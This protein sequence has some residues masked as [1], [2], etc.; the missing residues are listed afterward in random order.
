MIFASTDRAR[1][2]ALPPGADFPQLFAQGL[3]RRLAG[4][5]PESRA[6]I[7]VLV[8]SGRMRRRIRECLVAQGPGLLPRIRLVTEPLLFDGAPQHAPPVAPLRR[9]LELAQLVGTLQAAN[10]NLAPRAAV[11][12]LADSLAR[13]FAEMQAEG[14]GFRALDKL[15]LSNHADHWA[16]AQRFLH[17]AETVIAPDAPDAEGR[18]RAQVE[19]LTAKW[20]DAPPAESMIVAGSTG[21]RGTTALLMKAIARLPQGAVVLP[22]FDFDMP[23]Q[24]WSQLDDTAAAEDHPQYRFHALL[25]SLGLAASD[26]APWDDSPPLPRGPLVSLALRPAPQTD[27]WLREG[28]ALGDLVAATEGLGLI[29]A[30]SPRAEATAIAHCLFDAATRGARA[31]L[32]T[33]DRDLTRR[34]AAALQVWGIS[35]DDSAGR[36][37]GLSAPGRFLRQVAELFLR[38]LDVPKLLALLKHPLAH[39]GSERGAHLLHTR[40]LEL[41]LR[42]RSMPFP[43]AQVLSAFA[44]DDGPRKDWAR[45]LSTTLPAAPDPSPRPLGQLVADHLTLAESLAAGQAGTCAGGLWDE[46]AGLEARAAMDAL[47]T[48]ADAGGDLTP[49]DYDT[50]LANIFAGREVREPVTAHPD[51]MIWGTLEARVQGADLVIAAGLNEGVW[52]KAPDPD[53]W[54]NRAMRAQVGLLLPDRQIGLSAHDFQQAV[55]APRVVLSRAIR[56]S[57]AQ[58]VPS[59]W[60]NRLTNLMKGLPEQGGGAALDAMRARGQRWLDQAAAFEADFRKV[61]LDKPAARPAPAPPV[62]PHQ[63]SVT[64]V[65]ALIRDPYAVYARHV[66][67]LRRLNPLLPMPDAL[68]RGT[69]LHKVLEQA[70]DPDAPRPLLE[71]AQEV[72]GDA[73]PWHAVRALWWARLARVAPELEAYLAQQP[74]EI[75]LRETKAGWELRDPPFTLTA[76]PD[77]IDIWPDGRVHILDYKTGAPPTETEQKEFSKQLLLQAVMAQEGAFTGLGP[78][79]VARVTYLG[80]GGSALKLSQTD[81]TPALIDEVREGFVTLIRAYLDPKQGFAARRAVQKQNRAGDYDHLA[82]FGEWTMQDNSVTIRVGWDH[83]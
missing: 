65:E 14:V 5:R 59:R 46:A 25:Q 36:P 64:Q 27:Q 1:V 39:S 26:V 29:E 30:P 22:G 15:D 82:R 4:L 62:R 63:L 19:S 61:R 28:P 18:L 54:L 13:L 53:P 67:G 69:V 12:D 38:R 16:Q 74:G 7:T 8:N 35:P 76:K 21:S 73:V 37:L 11:F 50:L 57:E 32:V 23:A 83:D 31:A 51:V 79:E 43:D 70:T 3:H 80:L 24:A 2:F 60:L 47:A 78:R 56:T 81:M 9:R 58:T 75:A 34:V 49:F 44:A 45:W 41:F 52:P 72:L 10:P 71:V 40:D 66:L 33:P 6:R 68:L 77:R 20:Q 48:E 17:L 42:A 55:C